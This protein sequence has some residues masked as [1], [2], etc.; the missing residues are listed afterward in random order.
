MEVVCLEEEFSEVLCCLEEVVFVVCCCCCS[1]LLLLLLL[2]LLLR[3]TFLGLNVVVD[4]V[5]GV[6]FDFVV[7]EEVVGLV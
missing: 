4:V 7:L 6:D 3:S 1:S 5:D 2:F